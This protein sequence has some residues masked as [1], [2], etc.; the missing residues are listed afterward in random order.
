[1]AM[2]I[3]QSGPLAGQPAEPA[4]RLPSR[5]LNRK[6]D[7]TASGASSEDRATIIEIHP[8]LGRFVSAN[9]RLNAIAAN[10]RMFDTHAAVVDQAVS[11]MKQSLERITKSFPPFPP[12]SEDRARELKSYASLRRQI[13]QLAYPPEDPA[14]SAAPEERV[15]DHGAYVFVLESNGR[16]RTV[17][18]DDV[19]VGPS[20]IIIP[21]VQASA[22]DEEIHQ[23]AATLETTA[24]ALTER[25]WNSAAEARAGAASELAARKAQVLARGSSAEAAELPL[26]EQSAQ[27]ISLKIR[28]DLGVTGGS[29]LHTPELKNALAGA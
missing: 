13:D 19:H 24:Q 12:G 2:D 28:D 9:E 29:L 25:R 22:T 3:L 16:I 17:P 15:D 14:G 11:R 21:E 1:M 23:A 18:R 27:M 6:V 26:P 7:G 4:G 8:D 20:G 5:G 10:A